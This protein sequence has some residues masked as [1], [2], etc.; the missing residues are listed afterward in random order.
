VPFDAAEKAAIRN[1]PSDWNN[2][3]VTEPLVLPMGQAVVGGALSETNEQV[4]EQDSAAVGEQVQDTVIMELD[5]ETSLGSVKEVGTLDALMKRMDTTMDDLILIKGLL[6]QDDSVNGDARAWRS[7]FSALGPKEFSQI[8][9]KVQL[10]FDQ[11]R[12]AEHLAGNLTTFT[13]AH[14]LS[15]IRSVAPNQ[16][17][18]VVNVLVPLCVDQFDASQRGLILNE[19]T[20]WER[21]LTRAVIGGDQQALV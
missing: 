18:T 14:I 20:M 1:L 10:E 17:A 9:G 6:G 19:L 16:R 11:P 8:V 21:I 13:G 3:I 2:A 15:T 12:V 4:E 5:A 7:L